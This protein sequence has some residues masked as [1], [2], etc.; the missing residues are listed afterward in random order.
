M[1]KVITIGRQFGSGGHAIG[2][3]VA[4]QLG[5]PCYDK[6]ML[7]QIAAETGFLPEYIENASEY[8]STNNSI[9]WNLAMSLK[10]GVVPE[11]NPSD[12]IYFAQAKIIRELADRES[13]VIVGRCGD[14]I[15]KD[16]TDCLHVFI[17]AD[18]QSREKR[19][20]ERYG[21]SVKTVEKH[22]DDKD[23]RRR[24]Y[25]SHY[26]DRPWGAP[27]N[28]HITLNSRALGEE[29]C[30]REIIRLALEK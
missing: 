2:E 1:K 26:T 19:I 16:R 15:L 4:K 21:D 29:A 20:I 22:I 6:E 14:Y 5:I 24:L 17:C 7:E 28:Y 25:Y 30:V 11:E 13:C 9:L 3:A 27:E 10:S 8:S 12:V 23:S 18:K